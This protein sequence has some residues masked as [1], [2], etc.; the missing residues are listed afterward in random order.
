M[1]KRLVLGRHMRRL[2]ESAYVTT[3]QAAAAIRGSSSKISRLEL[4]RVSF[5][6]RDIADLLTLYG[7]TSNDE[8]ESLMRLAWEAN[9]RP[10]WHDYSD[11]LPA[12]VEPYLDLE[13]TAADI[14]SYETQLVHGLLQTEDYARAVIELGNIATEAE[15]TRRVEARLSRKDILNGPRSPRL[16]AVIDEGALRRPIGSGVVMRDQLQYLID[17]TEHPAITL[18]V[19]PFQAGGHPALGGSFTILQFREIEHPGVV[20]VEQ[21]TSAL[22][23]DR[24]AETDAY[25]TMFKQG[26]AQA[27]TVEDTPQILKEILTDI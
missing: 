4:G 8:Y 13:A 1:M 24:P 26:A 15:I 20:Y 6:Q 19:L 3:E 25:L 27:E 14:R 16:W 17:M 21:L 12:W 7:V 5:K 9:E 11:V 23:M 18:Q 22:Y 10:W 2:R